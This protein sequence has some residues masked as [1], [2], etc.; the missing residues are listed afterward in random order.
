MLGIVIVLVGRCLTVG[1]LD[2]S[3]NDGL[4]EGAMS[5][6]SARDVAT[7]GLQLTLRLQVDNVVITYLYFG[8]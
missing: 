6:R 3:G 7:L 5:F 4:L 8:G 2:P 1:Y